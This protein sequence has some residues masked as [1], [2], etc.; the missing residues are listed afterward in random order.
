MCRLAL[1]IINCLESD[2]TE[3]DFLQVCKKVDKAA[4]YSDSKTRK[5][6]TEN[7]ALYLKLPVETSK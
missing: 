6:T 4:E 3:A 5:I 1:D 7:V 2:L